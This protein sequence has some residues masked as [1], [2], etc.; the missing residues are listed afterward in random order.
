MAELLR[1]RLHSTLGADYALTRELGGGGMSRVFLARD[2]ALE[3]DVFV[4]V[5]SARQ[6]SP[7]DFVRRA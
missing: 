5:L 1:D 4:S 3:R 2:A 6:S 7:A